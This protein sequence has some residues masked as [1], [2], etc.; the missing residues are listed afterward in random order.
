MNSEYIKEYL[1]KICK[2]DLQNGFYYHGK[3][4]TIGDDSLIIKDKLGRRVV[5][6]F[7]IIVKIEE[8]KE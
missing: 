2:V 6:A 4:L 7:S 5:I 1:G 3:I 8:V